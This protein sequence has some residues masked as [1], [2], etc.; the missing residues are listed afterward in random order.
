VNSEYLL[1]VGVDGAERLKNVQL[2][3]GN[4]SKL[5]L[6][7]SGLKIGMTV[8]DAGCGTGLMTQWL[9]KE[10]GS[11]GQVIA[12]DNSPQQ[13]DFARKYLEQNH[14]YNVNYVCKNVNELSYNDLLP[15]DLFYARLLLV[16]NKNPALLLNNIKNNCKKNTIF[17]FEE[18]ITSES[19]CY[20][21]NEIFYKHLELYCKLGENA[22]FDYDFGKTLPT[23]IANAG[24]K[25]QGIRTVKNYFSSYQEKLIA[26]QRTREC[27]KKYIQN[28]LIDEHKLEDLQKQLL[29]L[30]NNPTTLISGVNMLQ[31]WGI[32]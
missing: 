27:A 3:Y 28:N 31:I 18:P 14:I 29:E 16:H 9:S 12:L 13:I 8:L 5:L 23:L 15:L 7:K 25:I 30:A 4:E 6:Q 2:L 1:S 11:T 26:Y 17:V 32:V 24:L 10:I 19:D 21:Y 22:G 20:P